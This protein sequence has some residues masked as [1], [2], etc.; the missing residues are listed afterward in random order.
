MVTAIGFRVS[1]FLKPMVYRNLGSGLFLGHQC[2]VRT[3]KFK[4]I[5]KNTEFILVRRTITYNSVFGTESSVTSSI[6]STYRNQIK[7]RPS[8]FFNQPLLLYHFAIVIV[9]LCHVVPLLL[10]NCAIVIVAAA[11]H[12]LVSQCS[13][14]WLI[15]IRPDT[16]N[17]TIHNTQYNTLVDTDMSNITIHRYTGST[18]SPKIIENNTYD[19]Y[20]KTFTT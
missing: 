3:A 4:R 9:L 17:N 8:K 18:L 6:L 20:T 19:T 15:L 1:L 14:G 10:Y 11:Q 16:S 5:N 12:H 2:N 13:D 7:R